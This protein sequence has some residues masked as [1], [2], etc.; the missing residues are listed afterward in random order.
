MIVALVFAIYHFIVNSSQYL[1]IPY[2]N[3]HSTLRFVSTCCIA[4]V[5]L[6]LSFAMYILFYR[7]IPAVESQII[8]CKLG[9]RTYQYFCNVIFASIHIIRSIPD[10]FC[11]V[12][13][14]RVH[15]PYNIININ[16]PVDSLRHFFII[17]SVF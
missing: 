3:V 7:S 10:Y 15:V 5:A 8:H 9:L 16:L 13:L 1:L 6:T 14:L 4:N 11:N 12:C 2:T 17:P